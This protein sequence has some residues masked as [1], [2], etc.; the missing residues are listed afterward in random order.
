MSSVTDKEHSYLYR[1]DS[2]ET[3]NRQQDEISSN[4]IAVFI[5]MI[6]VFLLISLVI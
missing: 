4:L 6:T 1:V 2:K 5:F 3:Y